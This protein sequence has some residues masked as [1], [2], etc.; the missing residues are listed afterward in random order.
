MIGEKAPMIVWVVG[1]NTNVG[2]TTISAALIRVLN[3][4]GKATVGFKPYAGG[5]LLDLLNLLEEIASGDGYLVG[6][7]AR[8][9]AKASSSLMTGDLLEVVNPSWRLSHPV[10]NVSVFIRK[11]SSAIGKRTFFYTENAK[12]LWS[13]TDLLKLNQTMKLPITKLHTLENM[14][15]DKVDFEDQGVQV[16]SFQHLLALSPDIVV[17]EGAGRLLPVWANAP[18]ARHLFFISGGD[19]YFFPNVGIRV[20]QM[21]GSFGP[22]TIATIAQQLASRKRL[23]VSIPLARHSSLDEEM[24][25]FMEPFAAACVHS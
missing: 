22:F 18:A 2:K 3:R 4:M 11:G 21:Q 25:R 17:C 23:K 14:E 13:R 8:K 15:A 9:L 24:E 20:G 7:D 5:R 16:A 1:D 19:L 10:R 12:A 6:H